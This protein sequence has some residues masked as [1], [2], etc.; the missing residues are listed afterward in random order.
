M[1]ED[2][3]KKLN[4]IW[5]AL[6]FGQV[7]FL[8]VIL[9]VFQD[10]GINESSQGLLEYVAVGALLPMVMMSQVLYKKQI[11]RAQASEAAEEDKLMMYQTATIV[12]AGLL[13]GGNIFCLVA[14]LLTGVQW[15]L[16]P[17]VAVLGLFFMQRP[18]VQKYDIEVGSRF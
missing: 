8:C 10:S 15:L 14:Y 6:I 11:Q 5:F 18:S 16:I 9:L 3:I 12:K 7:I 2:F 4:I 1:K 13:E 17:I